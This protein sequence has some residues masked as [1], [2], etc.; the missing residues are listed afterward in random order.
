MTLNIENNVIY[1]YGKTINLTATAT[2]KGDRTIKEVQFFRNDELIGTAAAAPYSIDYSG[3]PEGVSYMSARAVDS[4]G[5][6]T[7]SEIKVMNINYTESVGDWNTLDI[8]NATMKGGYAYRDGVY[9][10]KSSGLI[11]AGNE[12]NVMDLDPK[13]D[14]FSF[15]YKEADTNS[16]ISTKIESVSKFNNNC[17]SGIMM[18]DE[19]TNTSDFVMINYEHEK[20]GSGLSFVYRL[21]GEYHKD[22]LRL[23]ELPRYVKLEKIGNTIS[24]YHSPNG[25]DWEYFG[26]V[27]V[28]FTGKNYAGIAQ[29][30]N[31]ETNQ[32]STY[33]WGRFTDLK[34]ENYG[35]NSVPKVQLRTGTV[36]DNGEFNARGQYYSNESI[37]LSISSED[38]DSIK[39]TE[40][41]VDGSLLESYDENKSAVTITPLSVGNHYI[42]VMV[43]DALGAKNSA[44]QNV[45]VSS[46]N[47]NSIEWDIAEIHYPKDV[48]SDGN[49][50]RHGAFDLNG[51]KLKIYAT[52]YGIEG[53]ENEEY[54]VM[55][56][57]MSGDFKISFKVDEQE[58]DGDYEQMGFVVRN[59]M[60]TSVDGST[61]GTSYAAYF[62]KYNG[63][64]FRKTDEYGKT[65][66]LIGQQKYK[67]VPVWISLEKVGDTLT[68]KYSQDNSEWVEVG[69]VVADDLNDSYYLGVFGA[70][71]EEYKIAEFDISDFNLTLDKSA[72][73]ST[74]I[75]MYGYEWSLEAV[76]ALTDMGVIEGDVDL[77]GNRH[78]LPKYEVTRSEF[79]KMLVN[80]YK[81]KNPTAQ[82]VRT[83]TDDQ[84]KDALKSDVAWYIPYIYEAYEYGLCDGD[85]IY[86]YANNY[87]ELLIFAPGRCVT[88]EEM[89]AMVCRA[90][91]DNISG[92]ADGFKDYADIS[93][94]A[95][96]YVGKIKTS[97]IM[98]G[99]ENGLFNPQK[100]ADRAEAAQVIYNYISQK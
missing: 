89:A 42:T 62:Q 28:N 96:D 54:P 47:G 45:A 16:V 36:S 1:D 99:D 53:V 7:L 19:L 66:E 90:L 11:G 15:M 38:T 77:N 34:L 71:N 58:F 87:E 83:A 68:M 3:A 20:G 72:A 80:A 64:L 29:D 86:D 48:Q 4:E 88:R 98:Q 82:K 18:R 9:T 97:G 35:E 55:Y 76:E 40:V 94:W 69:T 14:D 2:A 33:S 67:K 100:F 65:Y 59:S 8:G 85:Y 13:T 63:E 93:D 74:Y 6:A 26:E 79:A 61:D 51:D 22:F 95:K 23:A 12:F 39:K 70:S 32:I 84:F 27:D 46:F 25:I 81:M 41:Y 57:K 50:I 52:G 43:Y 73:S 21:N 24:G 17:V 49:T 31:K 91:G 37:N 10:V 78:F 30:G 60:T 5:E 44:T 92:S 75:D 56:T